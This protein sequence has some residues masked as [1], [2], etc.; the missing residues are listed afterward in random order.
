MATLS[1]GRTAL[2]RHHNNVG[3]KVHACSALNGEFVHLQCVPM[4]DLSTADAVVVQ[5]EQAEQV[6]FRIMI[7]DATEAMQVT[8]PMPTVSQTLC[9]NIWLWHGEEVWVSSSKPNMYM[10]QGTT[11]TAPIH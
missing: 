9:T 4:V 2:T 8:L 1:E 10:M 6:S 3:V 7:G 5:R 11:S